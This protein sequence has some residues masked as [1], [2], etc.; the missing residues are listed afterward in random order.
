HGRFS[1][2][3]PSA[4]MWSLTASARGY[5]T[6]AYEEHESFSS[7]IVLTAASPGVDLRFSLPPES[8]IWGTVLDE[9]GEPVRNAR[10]SLMAIHPP[11]PDSV[12]LPGRPH[13]TISTDDRGSYEFDE[14]PPGDY[15]VSVQAQVWYAVA[16]QQKNTNASD[17][18]PLDPSLDVAYPLTWYPGTSDPAEAETLTLH[19]GDSR[20]ANFQLLPIP[21]VHLRILPEAGAT[22]NGRRVQSYPM[23]EQITPDGAGFVPV[24][25]HI[26]P[27]G[28]IDVSG[29]AP[30]QYEI[31]M[32]APG[33]AAKPALVDL[34][35]GSVQTLDMNAA[36]TI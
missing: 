24:S 20:Q 29:L 25:T 12:Q 28:G 18:P 16:S 22:A 27:Q 3:L 35:D 32:Q 8:V 36:S 11:G 9:A 7:A 15:R 6:Q 17:Q 21:S 2:A 31:R 1:I 19:A 26:D 33:Q 5:V 14:L 34:A 10:V 13:A 4:G 23:I 30:G